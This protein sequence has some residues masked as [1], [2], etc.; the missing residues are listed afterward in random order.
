MRPYFFDSFSRASRVRKPARFSDDAQLGVELDERAGDAHAQG[1]GLAGDAAAVDGDVDVVGLLDAGDPQR[2]GDDHLV[3][4]RREVHRQLP[5][6][7]GDR[8]GAGTQADA[9]DGLLAAAGGLGEGLG[10]DAL[11]RAWAISR[12]FGSWAECGWSGPA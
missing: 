11:L 12:G 4:A 5:L 2:L 8:A 3:R 6:V 10:H 7:D 1:A 9:G